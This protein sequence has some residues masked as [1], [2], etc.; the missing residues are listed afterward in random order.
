MDIENYSD[1]SFLKK[2]SK[3]W[4]GF[5]EPNHIDILKRNKR[6]VFAGSPLNPPSREPGTYQS[7]WYHSDKPEAYD[8][9]KRHCVKHNLHNHYESNKIVYTH[10]EDGFRVYPDIS[11]DSQKPSIFF[12]GCSH[13]HG[14]GL[15]DS[16]T[17][18]HILYNKLDGAYNV[19]N[20]GIGGASNEEH[21]RIMYQVLNFITEKPRAI[22][23]RMTHKYRR[24]YFSINEENALTHHRMKINASHKVDAATQAAYIKLIRE[25]NDII[26]VIRNYKFAETLCKLYNIP[27]FWWYTY[28]NPRLFTAHT[29]RAIDNNFK[30]KPEILES[31]LSE[32]FDTSKTFSE[33]IPEDMLKLPHARDAMHGGYKSQIWVADRLL[34]LLKTNNL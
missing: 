33:P 18:P 9:F 24:E 31:F 4:N 29:R 10:D 26:N 32:F 21:V 14:T 6:M 30:N 7:E 5:F 3:N 27:L 1:G 22:V 19:R 11:N 23:W 34:H 16:E 8:V 20:F 28:G 25:E 15:L 12:F 13:M 2:I 17:L